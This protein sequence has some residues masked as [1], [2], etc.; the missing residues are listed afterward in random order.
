MFC[1]VCTR[2]N[3]ITI[4]TRN[5][6]STRQNH[7]EWKPTDEFIFELHAQHNKYFV[8][9]LNDHAKH[10]VPASDPCISRGSRRMNIFTYKC[11][12][13]T[14]WCKDLL[15]LFCVYKY[16]M[17]VSWDLHVHRGSSHFRHGGRVK[18]EKERTA[19]WSSGEDD[20]EEDTWKQNV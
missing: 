14:S 15:S 17:E 12:K 16:A 13:F 19:I 1:I 7:S 18:D 10:A 6:S 11:Y 3:D 4:I 5:S 20:W 9:P 8:P 2:W